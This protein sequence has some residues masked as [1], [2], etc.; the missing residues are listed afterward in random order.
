M[1]TIAD[2]LVSAAERCPERGMGVHGLERIRFD[3]LL[4]RSQRVAGGLRQAGVAPGEPVVL[5]THRPEVFFPAFWGVVLA[6]GTAVPLAGARDASPHEARR[7]RRVLTFMKDPRVLEDELPSGKPLHEPGEAP[8]LVQFSSGTTRHPAGIVLE[9]RHLIANVEQM[10]ARFPIH[11]GDLKLTWMPHYH[12]MGLIGCHLLPLAMGMEQLRMRP[13]QAMRDPLVWLRAAE[14]SGATLLSTTNFALARATERLRGHAVDLS[15]VRHIFNG[16]EPIQPQVCRAFCQ[17]SGL[18]D[19]VH[20]P[21]YGL[22]EASVGVCAPD[23]GGL[24]TIEVDGLERVIIGPLLDG[25][26]GRVVDGELQVRGPNV[27]ERLWGEAPH[28]KP[29]VG[30]GDVVVDT[31][32]GL[33][34]VGRRKDLVV[35]NGRNLH[36]DDVEH[37]AEEV[38]GVRFAVAFP[39]TRDEAEALALRVQVDRGLDP[40]PVL[41][42]LQD[43]LR[44]QLER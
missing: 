27:H 43:H 5:L 40:P 9:H 13:D 7:L 22:A 4:E 20:V 21:L 8:P 28:G 41:W 44:G 30:T 25:M 31:P 1:R 32:Q 38:E 17:V 10:V 29:W 39:E 18:P 15:R 6:G 36:A 19:S 42:A 14:E 3:A 26:Q 16:A 34:I 24:H 35:V 23:H 33:A 12:D 11:E 2:W 37:L